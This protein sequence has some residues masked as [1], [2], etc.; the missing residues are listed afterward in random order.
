MYTRRDDVL[1]LVDHVTDIEQRLNVLGEMLRIVDET[2]TGVK[3]DQYD[4]DYRH[5]LR[6][7][8]AVTRVKKHLLETVGLPPQAVPKP[9][10]VPNRRKAVDT[11]VP[12]VEAPRPAGT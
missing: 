6:N 1:K 3:F 8:L 5:E 11:D 10:K 12:A 2:L 7:E 4:T 9:K